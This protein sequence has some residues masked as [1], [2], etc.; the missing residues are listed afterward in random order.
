V[1]RTKLKASIFFLVNF[2]FNS[3]KEIK[4]VKKELKKFVF[5]F[6]VSVVVLSFFIFVDVCDL[7]H[8]HVLVYIHII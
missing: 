4:K 2:S 6:F 8:I 1:Q 7:C 3:K 5:V